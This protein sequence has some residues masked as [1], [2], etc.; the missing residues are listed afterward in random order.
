[1][2]YYHYHGTPHQHFYNA[3]QIVLLLLLLFLLLFF[4]LYVYTRDSKD[5]EG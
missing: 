3:L 4:K 5:P 1:M 2:F